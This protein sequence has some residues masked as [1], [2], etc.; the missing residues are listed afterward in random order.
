MR[1]R[2]V[3]FSSLLGLLLIAYVAHSLW[4]SN[5]EVPV[6][7][8]DTTTAMAPPSGGLAAFD[9]NG[10]GIVY[11]DPMHPWIVLDAPGKAPDCGM[12]LVPVSIHEGMDM[13]TDG[14]VRIDPVVLQNTGVRLTT[15]EVAPLAP[16]VRATARLEV[17]EQQL[18]AVSPKISG[19]VEVL[20][21]D[22]EGARVRKGEPLLEIYSPELVSTQEEYLLA[23]RNV[24][25]LAGTPAEADARRLLEA[26]RRRLLFWDITDQQIQQLEETGQ[27]R[28][29][30]TLYAPAS[31]TVLEKKVVEG[32]KIQA[33]QTL[34]V[35]ADLS[36]LWLQ[37]DVYEHDLS[38]VVPGI[39]A[40]ITLPYDPTVRL[41][42]YV[43]YV[44]DTLDP[45]TRTAQARIV[46]PNPG[47][48]LKPGMYAVATL[49]G[50]PTPPRPLVP[51]EAIVRYG[52]EAFVIVAL[53]EGRFLPTRVQVG[54]EA[55]GYAQI[56][57]G[58]QGGEQIVARAQFLIDS[59]ARLKSA[60]GALMS[61]HQHGSAM[62][63]DEPD[64]HS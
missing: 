28:K 10:D 31:G 18:V 27:P 49:H 50:R 53:G 58:L 11:Q 47:L 6:A 42:G 4:R 34:F 35:L 51:D 12:D 25:Q 40:E 63:A 20:Y 3:L 24:R 5:A 22:Y 54:H 59:E 44:Y 16:T 26:A 13:E 64:A 56:L 33:G 15:V 55:N 48:R 17:N 39:R 19:W 46:V 62:E 7:S 23:L 43:D 61:G 14:S 30:L 38:W 2:I 8:V 57:D 9:K 45:T 37:V 52:N 36:T 29:T 1:T 21:V 41:E 32:Q 60:L